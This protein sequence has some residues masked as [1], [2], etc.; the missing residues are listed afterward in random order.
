MELV[1]LRTIIYD[2]IGLTRPGA[3]P[4]TAYLLGL[5]LVERVGPKA[6]MAM[7]GHGDSA[8]CAGTIPWSCRGVRLARGG[9]DPNVRSSGLVAGKTRCTAPPAYY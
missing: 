3:R 6:R 2:E 1:E 8:S 4:G 7:I 5:P 9:P